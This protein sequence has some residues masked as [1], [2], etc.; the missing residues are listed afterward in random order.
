[1]ATRDKRID[2]MRR[3]PR[4]VTIEDI[5]AALLGHGFNVRSQGTSH[6]VFTHRLL[7]GNLSIPAHRPYVAPVYV[8]QLLKALDDVEAAEALEE[9]LE[10]GQ[11]AALSEEDETQ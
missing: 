11:H 10:A 6:R 8:R 5:E 4:T 9:A 3:N 1:V 2:A 7:A